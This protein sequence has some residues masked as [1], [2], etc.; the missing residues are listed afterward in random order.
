MAVSVLNVAERSGDSTRWA[1][2]TARVRHGDASAEEELSRH[3]Y[4]RVL[5]MAVV[6][7]RDPEV[8]REIAQDVL[9]AVVVALREGKLREPEKLPGFVSGTARNLVNNHFRSQGELPRTVELDP[10]TP[11]GIDL[12]TEVELAEQRQRVRAVLERIAPQDR[13]ILLLTLVDGMNPREIA[14]RVGLSFENVRTRKMRA[15]RHVTEELRK[16]SRKKG[17]TPLSRE[18]AR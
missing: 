7:L 8:A 10:E 14:A 4:P 17:R 6:R 2:L 5:A 16:V 12:E 11:S 15:I 3:F 1:S 13:A 9:L 18:T